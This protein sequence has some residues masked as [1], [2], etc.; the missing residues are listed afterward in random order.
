MGTEEWTISC[1]R[2]QKSSAFSVETQG[3]ITSE[4]CVVC[5]A[6]ERLLLPTKYLGGELMLIK[7]KI[8]FNV[9]YLECRYS[10]FS[11]MFKQLVRLV[12]EV[13]P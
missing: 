11:L 8:N 1:F 6:A 13:V 3:K 7:P 9:R 5:Y 2:L 10:G 12:M 4:R